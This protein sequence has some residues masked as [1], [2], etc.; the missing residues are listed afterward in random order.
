MSE[1][2]DPLAFGGGGLMN[3]VVIGLRR[4]GWLDVP[5][6]AV[7]TEGAAVFAASIA[8]GRPVVADRIDTIATSL[9]SRVISPQALA[10]TAEH[11]I[12]S[13]TVSDRQALDAAVRFLDEH[14]I[15]VEPACGAALAAVTSGNPLL[16]DLPSLTVV[17]CGGSGVSRE[18]LAS[19]DATLPRG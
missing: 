2:N 15:M 4:A 14:R 7:E 1:P 3:G 11:P 17:V 9:S 16:D 12:R 6:V 13:M 5:V 18:L 8:A 10:W 19:W